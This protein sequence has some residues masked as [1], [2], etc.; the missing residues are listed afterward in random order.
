MVSLQ[1]FL[2]LELRS[3][4]DAFAY[5]I[6]ILVLLVRPQGLIVARSTRTR[7]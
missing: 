3:Y 1:A 4:R 5:A 2:P 7:V 6:V